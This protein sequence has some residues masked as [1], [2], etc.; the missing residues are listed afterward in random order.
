M[1]T[2]QPERQIEA[3]R[4]E[5]AGLPMPEEWKPVLETREEKEMKDLIQR[6]HQQGIEAKGS[7][8]YLTMIKTDS[9]YV[10]VVD[11]SG[12][13][14]M[15]VSLYRLPES[16]L[17]LSQQDAELLNRAINSSGFSDNPDLSATRALIHYEHTAIP[18]P[19]GF[20]PVPI[21]EE[22]L[23]KRMRGNVR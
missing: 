19:L 10:G 5:L 13:W 21:A 16:I 18:V 4:R 14:R 12:D 15:M 3:A 11:Q 1:S 17:S 7:V 8:G 9:W 2:L 22:E 6:L 20:S 23:M